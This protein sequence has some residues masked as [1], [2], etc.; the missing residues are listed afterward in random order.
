[1]KHLRNFGRLAFVGMIAAS[2]GVCAGNVVAQV[3]NPGGPTPPQP[4][5]SNVKAKV[6]R[7]AHTDPEEVREILDSLLEF[8][9]PPQPAQPPAFF[10]GPGPGGAPGL[11][12]GGLG[13]LG[14]GGGFGGNPMVPTYTTAI[15]ARTRALIVRGT[16]KDLQIATD[17]VSVLDL[18]KDKTAPEVKS[19]R[20]VEL[21]NAEA[22]QLI[23]TLEALNLDARIVPAPMAKLLII[24]GTEAG[25]KE[26][27]ELIKDLDV[28]TPKPK[29]DE[30]RRLLREKEKEPKQ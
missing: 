15:D 5:K 6:F 2:L 18:A 13:Q 14:I 28:V 12:P 27:G 29:P 9:A 7:L 26:A 4:A 21:K 30:E 16:E 1:M 22:A 19:L 3:G 20:V 17:L 23:E 25:M 11:A 24:T 8:H 10:G